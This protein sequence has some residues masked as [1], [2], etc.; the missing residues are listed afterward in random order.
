MND[1]PE[2]ESRISTAQWVERGLALHKQGNLAEAKRIYLQV[3]ADDPD[4]AEALHLLGLAAYQQGDFDE[5]LARIEAAIR[6]RPDVAKYHSNR[7]NTLKEKGRIDEAIAA[8][9][10]AI[11]IDPGFADASFNLGVTL[12]DGGDGEGAARA[13]QAVLRINPSNLDAKQNLATVLHTLGWNDQAIDLFREVLAVR[14]DVPEIHYNLSQT[15]ERV[16][17]YAEAIAEARMALALA[18]GYTVAAAA[19]YF[20]LRQSCTWDSVAD[21]ERLLD[22]DIDAAEPGRRVAEA[23][24]VSVGRSDDGARNLAVALSWGAD[25]AKGVRPL[26]T[27]EVA[28]RR[29]DGRLR[30]GYLSADMQN[31]AVAHQMLG[32]F[33]RHDR[34]RFHVTVYSYGGDDGSSYRRQIAE[35]CDAFVDIRGCVHTESAR[36]IRADGID[37]LVDLTGWT[38]GH[39]LVINA[40]RPAPIQVSYLGFP[41]TTGCRFIDYA[42]VDPVVVPVANAAHFS[43]A[44]VTMPYSYMVTDDRQPIA[45][46]EPSR[47]EAGLPADAFVFC[48]FNGPTKIEPVMFEAWTRL[49]WAIP[50]SVLWLRK[51]NDMAA[52]NLWSAAGRRG[53]RPDRLVF[54]DRVAD[55]AEYLR[56]LRLADLALDTR[57]YNGHATTCDALWAGVPVVTLE[58]RHF[59]SR[60]S[61]SCLRA[62]GLDE[63]VTASLADYEALALRLAGDRNELRRIRERLAVNRTTFPLF[64]TA[65][66]VRHLESAFETMWHRFEA[67][68]PPESF[69]VAP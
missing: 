65:L 38:R 48:S 34:S 21:V 36:K 17:R 6:Q 13:F 35:T 32:L 64:D 43:E 57:I 50:G 52:R 8:Y 10:R 20:Q 23:P 59:A 39:R 28:P 69:T 31:H 54:A 33:A 12:R 61:A 2:R 24:F 45:E 44:L 66:F 56:R 68:Q 9:R 51:P 7:G 14:R 47:D 53:I 15:F 5:A 18:P 63:M 49:L 30:I 19:L 62:V 58:G 29:P 27:T 41:G 11:E 55:K 40:Y 3:L 37:I 67:G 25:L 16:G 42:I 60:V 1:V 26:G 4:H 46:G 22:A